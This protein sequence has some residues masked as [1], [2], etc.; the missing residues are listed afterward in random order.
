[1]LC[2]RAFE[3]RRTFFVDLPGKK[4]FQ[5]ATKST[6]A[7]SGW[8][9]VIAATISYTWYTRALEK[10]KIESVTAVGS[11]GMFLENLVLE[12]VVDFR[13]CW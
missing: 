4:T 8:L 9:D 13:V 11:A 7:L 5:L 6:N 2:V 12:L 3:T 1:M 10:A